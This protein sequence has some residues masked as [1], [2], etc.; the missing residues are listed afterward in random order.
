MP[1]YEEDEEALEHFNKLKRKISQN[2]LLLMSGVNLL[3]F[4][5]SI[6]AITYYRWA[7]VEVINLTTLDDDL[8]PNQLWVNLLYGRAYNSTTY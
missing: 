6:F 2:R 1:A 8:S 7:V 3:T 4:S 5:L